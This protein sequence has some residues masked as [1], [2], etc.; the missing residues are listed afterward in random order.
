MQK[1]NENKRKNTMIHKKNLLNILLMAAMSFSIT[2]NIFSMRTKETPSQRRLRS[3]APKTHKPKLVSKRRSKSKTPKIKT[4]K[5]DIEQTE[6][7]I[8]FEEFGRDT[9]VLSCGHKYCIG[10]IAQWVE[11]KKHVFNGLTCPLCRKIINNSDI[12]IWEML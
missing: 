4:P 5:I 12:T 1:K 11:T 3:K 10:C 9:K 7:S 2:G 6:C 8:C